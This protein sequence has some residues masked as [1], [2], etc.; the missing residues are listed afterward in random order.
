MPLYLNSF[1]NSLNTKYKLTRTSPH[2]DKM[3][4]V[5]IVSL[6]SK[7]L[8]GMKSVKQ[9][10]WKVMSAKNISVFNSIVLSNLALNGYAL[11]DQIIRRRLA[12]IYAWT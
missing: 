3:N 2:T 10:K 9:T 12:N 6:A 4:D 7:S 5:P 8:S 1:N 11:A